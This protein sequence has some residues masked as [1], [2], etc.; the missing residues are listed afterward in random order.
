[1][2]DATGSP[3]LVLVVEEDYLELVDISETLIAAGYAVLQA[4]NSDQAIRILEDRTDVRLVYVDGDIEGTIDGMKLLH[5]IAHRWP[6]IR[7]FVASYRTLDPTTLPPGAKACR[8]PCYPS[9]VTDTVAGL[10][11][12]EDASS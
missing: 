4:S 7:L 12:A 8:K 10:L 9:V 3:A 5:F 1:M 11:G 6:P 2:A